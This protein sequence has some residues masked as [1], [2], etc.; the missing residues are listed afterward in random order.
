[1]ELKMFSFIEE[2]TECLRSTKDELKVVAKEIENYFKHILESN[3]EEYLNIKSRV[4]SVSSL[5]E[6]IIRNSYYKKYKSGEELISNLSDLIGIRIECRFIEDEGDIYTVLK[7]HYNKVYSDGLY[8]N[9]SNKKIR[10]ELESRQPQKQKNGFKIFRIDGVY[11]NDKETINFELQ[12]KSLVNVFWGEI[13]HK[14]I[15]KNNNY[16]MADNF[17]KDIMGSIK[18]NLSMIDNQLHIMDNQF[19][20]LNTINPTVR[21]AQIETTLSK[22]IYDIFSTKMKSSIGFVVEFRKS[23]DTIMKYIFRT[24]NA[25][26]LDD[27]NNTLVKTLTRL[28]DIGKNKVEF[29]TE[30]LFERD[31]VFEDDFS[32]VIGITILKSINTDFQWSL[33][34]R[35]LFEIE[36]GNNAEDFETFIAFIKNRFLGNNSFSK[37]HLYFEKEEAHNIIDS[38]MERIAYSFKKIDSIKF[39]YDDRMEQINE[40]ISETIEMICKDVKSYEEWESSS[41]I[42]LGLFTFKILS[43]FKYKIKISKVEDFIEDFKNCPAAKEASADILEYVGKLETLSEIKINNLMDLFKLNNI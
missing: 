11:E 41:E 9:E 42:Y 20:K 12:I 17:F 13:E 18:K 37:L 38:I 5:K 29:N 43:I 35:I 16:M 32:K 23:C 36:V 39:I 40:V 30:L 27:Y 1:M 33:F 24:N 3:D 25:Q 34:F 26:N 28:N 6:K 4:K 15:Y 19:N 7:Q 2:V 21:K 22:I 8:Y 10:L 14:I 31:I